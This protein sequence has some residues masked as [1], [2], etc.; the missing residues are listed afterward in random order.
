MKFL[1]NICLILTIQTMPQ[2]FGK[3]GFQNLQLQS[4]LYIPLADYSNKMKT[5]RD[6]MNIINL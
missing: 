4:I 2:F 6:S 1:G 5:K 3:R